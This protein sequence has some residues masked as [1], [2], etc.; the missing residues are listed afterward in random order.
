MFWDH[1]SS[2][3]GMLPGDTQRWLHNTPLSW[4]ICKDQ[5]SSLWQHF[6]RLYN[7]SLLLSCLGPFCMLCS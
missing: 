1:Q 6:V 2:T 7:L 3:E 4:V 5:L